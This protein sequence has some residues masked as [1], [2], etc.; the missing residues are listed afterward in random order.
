M[1]VHGGGTVTGVNFDNAASTPPLKRVRDAVTGF[2]E[3]Y[4]SVHRGTGYKSRLATEA[5]EQARE[6][7]DSFLNAKRRNFSHDG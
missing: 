6:N 4:S 1:P 7:V 5:Y 2:S 3:V